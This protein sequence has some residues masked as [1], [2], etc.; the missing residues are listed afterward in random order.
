MYLKMLVKDYK[1]KK[2]ITAVLFVFIFL[3]AALAAGGTCMFFSLTGALNNFFTKANIAHYVQFSGGAYDEAYAERWARNNAYIKEWS[4]QK[5]LN[6]ENITVYRNHDGETMDI[7]SFSVNFAAQNDNID[8]L[9]DMD[10]NKLSVADGYIAVPVI[11]AQRDDLEVGD[12]LTVTF[13]GYKKPFIISG[14]TRDAQYGSSMITVKR[15]ILSGNDY[16]EM[17]E[18][19]VRSGNVFCFVL[20]DEN[21]MR[22]FVKT[23]QMSDMPQDDFFLD[24][25]LFRLTNSTGDGIMIGLVLL[26]SLLLVM[27]T[28]LTLRYTI[29]S[30]IE[31]DFREIGVMKAIGWNLSGI[32]QMYLSKYLYLTV[33]ACILGWAAGQ[34]LSNVLSGNILLNMGV[35]DSG[36]T[37]ILASAGSSALILALILLFCLFTLRRIGKMTVTDALR[38]G[39][40]GET[41]G[42]NKLLSLSRR[43]FMGVNVFI[44][45]KDA[46]VKLKSY[47]LLFIVFFLCVFICILP[48][49]VK[50]TLAAIEFMGY[51]GFPVSDI[52]A[53]YEPGAGYETGDMETG[54]RQL[55]EL[56][57]NDTDVTK[58][59]VYME[60]YRYVKTGDGETEKFRIIVGDQTLFSPMYS[61][62]TPPILPNEIAVSYLASQD[63]GK[64]IGDGIIMEINGEERYMLITGIFPNMSNGGRSMRACYDTDIENSFYWQAYINVNGDAGIKAA[65]YKEKLSGVAVNTLESLAN[66][67]FVGDINKQ[68][69]GI[70]VMIAVIAALVSVLITALF[71]EMLTAKET[72]QIAVMKSLGFTLRHIRVQYFTR[73]GSVLLLA[74]ISGTIAVN[75]AGEKI[76]SAVCAMMG[77]NVMKFAINPAEVYFTY[78]PALF[79]VICVTVIL[80][81]GTVRKISISQVNAE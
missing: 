48:I 45:L 70:S 14:F 65:E 58:W 74:I 30:A 13:D 33:P 51:F 59:A 69:S 25:S 36:I 1:R 31:E 3:A 18:T 50:N 78:P 24:I 41:Y 39:N 7:E 32:T 16:K 17:A 76:M 26:C 9:L 38:M 77:A 60:E 40:I 20:K 44:G 43:R 8:I 66:D 61:D 29:L 54:L 56:L 81:C 4:V 2:V 47:I 53:G 10:N 49:N 46:A 12:A 72:P 21:M 27:I 37:V 11:H 55:T 80:S 23:F 63:L 73:I 64:G 71:V 42:E 75:T 15:F 19:G 6:P 67:Q 79:A 28:F 22:D 34:W 62:G 52:A 57:T 5:V 68:L 35:P